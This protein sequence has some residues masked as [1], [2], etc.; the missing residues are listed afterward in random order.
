MAPYL[1]LA[2][3]DRYYLGCAMTERFKRSFGEQ[4][5][6]AVAGAERPPV[7]KVRLI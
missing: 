7:V 5:G 6:G 3:P 4:W 2:L 1:T